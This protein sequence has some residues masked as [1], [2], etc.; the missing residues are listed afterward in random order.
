MS[1]Q[2]SRQVRRAAEREAAKHERKASSAN[3]MQQ[4][5]ISAVEMFKTAPDNESRIAM[6]TQFFDG[7]VAREGAPELR[8]QRDFILRLAIDL[9]DRN[10]QLREQIKEALPQPTFVEGDD[11]LADQVTFVSYT[12]LFNDQAGN[13]DAYKDTATYAGPLDKAIDEI[14]PQFT[15]AAW[16]IPNSNDI[17]RKTVDG[18]TP[19]EI[20]T[21]LLDLNKVERLE[22]DHYQK[23]RRE[24]FEEYYP[25][26]KQAKVREG[27]FYAETAEADPQQ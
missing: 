6:L 13:M 11:P 4:E 21:I 12:I 27:T 7:R 9:Q 2:P 15:F 18:L 24:L 1:N 20:R 8:R 19:E 22:P 10:N 3:N 25:K 17:S 14:L 26:I 5:Y 16:G 23:R